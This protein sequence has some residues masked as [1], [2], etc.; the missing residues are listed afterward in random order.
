MKPAVMEPIHKPTS[1]VPP[2]MAQTRDPHLHTFRAGCGRRRGRRSSCKP[3]DSRWRWPTR[4]CLCWD[5]VS[6]GVAKRMVGSR[7][8]SS[9]FRQ[10]SAAGISSAE[11]RRPGSSGRISSP[12][13]QNG[14]ATIITRPREDESVPIIS[15]E[16]VSG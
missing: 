15:G 13:C 2:S 11:T 4:R 8:T 10:G 7:L 6:V 16:Q 14:S 12:T 9:T 1:S 5:E 3:H